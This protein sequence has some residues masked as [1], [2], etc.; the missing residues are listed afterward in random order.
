M[1]NALRLELAPR[2]VRV[3]GLYV[4]YMDTDMTEGFDVEK[5]DPAEVATIALD[6]IAAGDYE[7]VVD[8]TSRQ[9]LAGLSGGVGA[10]YPELVAQ[11]V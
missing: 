2:D 7:V 6:G 3:S 5:M 10:L 8:E 9:V 4:G 1:T 11:A